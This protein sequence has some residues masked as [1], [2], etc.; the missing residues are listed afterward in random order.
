MDA[1]GSELECRETKDKL[2]IIHVI[3]VSRR[4]KNKIKKLINAKK[5][6]EKRLFFYY[7]SK[8]KF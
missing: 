4:L 3:T 7:E 8:C 5:S 1:F 6:L 2:V